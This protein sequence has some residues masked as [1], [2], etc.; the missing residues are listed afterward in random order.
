MLLHDVLADRLV[1]D[2]LDEGVGDVEIHV[3]FQ[4]RVA[5]QLKA[6]ADI[7]LGEPLS[8]E[9]LQGVRQTLGDAFE[10]NSAAGLLFCRPLR[11]PCI[12]RGRRTVSRLLLTGY[13]SQEE[14]VMLHM[15]LSQVVILLFTAAPAAEEPKGKTDPAGVAVEAK[16]VLKKESYPLNLDGKSAIEFKEMIK[17]AKEKGGIIPKP[18]EIEAT[19]ELKNTGDKEI[20]IWISGDPVV[21]TLEV[22]GKGALNTTLRRPFTTEF[23]GPKAITL[24][25]GKSHSIPIASTASGFRGQSRHGYWTEIG[26]YTLT[27]SFKTAVSPSPKDAKEAGEKGFGVVTVTSAPAKFKV[28]D[29]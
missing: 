15:A 11:E 26:D 24:E 23:R 3:G 1:G 29:N 4:E 21:L 17:R 7:R 20:Q 18:P 12:I 25:P 13:L 10:H 2:A 6:V 22:E 28:T 8:R 9:G 19:L 16:L 14:V 27:A 5:D